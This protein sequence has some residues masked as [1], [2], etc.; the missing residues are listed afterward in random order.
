MNT[1][2]TAKFEG[3]KVRVLGTAMEPMFVAKDVC[4]VLEIKNSR[5]ALARLD[6][7]EKGVT[8][9]DTLGGSQEMTYV[10]ES[11]LYHL[12]FKSRK[13]AAKRFRRWV[14]DEVIPS[15]RKTGSYVVSS[16]TFEE[17]DNQLT[18]TLD[19][20]ISRGVS[21]DKASACVSNIF[22]ESGKGCVNIDR[23]NKTTP[24]LL[25]KARYDSE[26]TTTDEFDF[27]ATPTL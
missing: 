20:W 26:T 5:Q 22:K 8:I 4:D 21:P 16:P 27:D 24:N 2:L 13:P 3:H 17:L 7:N 11:G 18:K 6:D 25:P 19:K 15:I 1:E 9:A 23:S 12:M 14:T 10:T